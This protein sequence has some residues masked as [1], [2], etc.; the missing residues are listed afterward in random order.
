MEAG[1]PSADGADSEAGRS[2]SSMRVIEPLL[3]DIL[4]LL[5]LDLDRIELG[6]GCDLHYR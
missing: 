2:T 6:I 5:G 3:P 1:S 4:E